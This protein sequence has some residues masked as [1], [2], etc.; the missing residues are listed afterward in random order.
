MGKDSL[1]SPEP[2]ARKGSIISYD[3]RSTTAQT[4][5]DRDP[6]EREPY[7]NDVSESPL[8]ETEGEVVIRKTSTNQLRLTDGPSIVTHLP[9]V[10]VFADHKRRLP[11][12]HTMQGVVLFLD[13]SG[14]TALCEKYSLAGKTGTDQLT[15]TLNGYM[16]ALVSEIL[17][18]DGDI[19]K[20]AGDA[21]LTLWQ[22]YSRS[23]F[24]IN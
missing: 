10:V 15:K 21:I 12:Q 24:G 20:F 14:F 4:R 18:Y 7:L 16:N 1:L 13:I 9:D 8:S 5:I 2:F 6:A 17:S 23:V 19:L 3:R 22:V 11:N